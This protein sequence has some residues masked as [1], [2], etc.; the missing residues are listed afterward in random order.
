KLSRTSSGSL[1][2]I[3]SGSLPAQRNAI[4]QT[5]SDSD[6]RGTLP[7]RLR[8]SS[9]FDVLV[10]KVVVFIDTL[11]PATNPGGEGG[12]T[13]LASYEAF[14]QVLVFLKPH[15]RVRCD[16]NHVTGNESN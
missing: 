8:G 2:H 6:K 10:D 5:V 13:V 1:S 9:I 4:S 16:A 14:Q 11:F 7:L 3:R 15:S 12:V